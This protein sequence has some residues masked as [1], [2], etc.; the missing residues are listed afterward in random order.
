MV[1]DNTARQ[2]MSGCFSW[3]KEYASFEFR[4][5]DSMNSTAW[6]AKA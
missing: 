6:T 4:D 3:H 1:D 2:L 5:K